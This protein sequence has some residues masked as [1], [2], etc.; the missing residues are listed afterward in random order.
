MA[1]I[2]VGDF[3]FNPTIKKVH[4][5][6]GTY[7]SKEIHHAIFLKEAPRKPFLKKAVPSR[8]YVCCI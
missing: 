5:A 2:L 6:F 3:D 8:N 4:A 7:E 1:I